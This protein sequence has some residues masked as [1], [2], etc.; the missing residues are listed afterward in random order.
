M[1]TNI[2][3]RLISFTPKIEK[4]T[5]ETVL[6]KRLPRRAKHVKSQTAADKVHVCL[7]K[8]PSGKTTGRRRFSNNALINRS[9]EFTQH[10]WDLDRHS[11]VVFST[12]WQHLY[13]IE[14]E[15]SVGPH[16]SPWGS[17]LTSA[18]VWCICNVRIM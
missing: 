6:L 15:R 13:D 3:R 10:S 17:E 16:E 1:A 4:W 2:I 8:R 12:K 11:I 14:A 18:L 7:P 9:Y 5:A